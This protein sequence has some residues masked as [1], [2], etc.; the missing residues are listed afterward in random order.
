MR[1][2]AARSR[3]A[4]CRA[5]TSSGHAPG[6]SRDS[7][8]ASRSSPKRVSVAS[9][10]CII[11]PRPNTS[12]S[13]A[14][15]WSPVLNRSLVAGSC[16][17]A[18]SSRASPRSWNRSAAAARS[19]ASMHPRVHH[20][21]R[22]ERRPPRRRGRRPRQL[23][24]CPQT[25]PPTRTSGHHGQREAGGADGARAPLERARPHRYEPAVLL[26]GRPG[27]PPR[28]C[29]H[30]R[31][32]P[33]AARESRRGRRA[34]RAAARRGSKRHR[35]G[36][37]RHRQAWGQAGASL[38]EAL[39]PR[40]DGARRGST[41]GGAPTRTASASSSAASR[42]RASLNIARRTVVSM[43]MSGTLAPTLNG[44]PE[45]RE[46]TRLH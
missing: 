24:R 9:T 10:S 6:S 17:H 8:F 40:V 32:D 16:S 38:D 13:A 44:R 27:R 42:R 18:W 14:N 12:R 3:T 28:P 7:S 5:S 29:Y 34:A 36:E 35:D 26:V 22:D 33:H 30:D 43:L 37:P 19:F 45:R 25:R 1:V 11:E 41:P 39:R 20:D 2:V 15:G 31:T 23:P 21:E 46:A 4:A